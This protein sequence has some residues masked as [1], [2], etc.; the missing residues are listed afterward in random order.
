V[1]DRLESTNLTDRIHTWRLHGNAG[2]DR[3][4]SFT[5]TSQ[6]PT[7]ER[8][9]AGVEVSVASTEGKP[10]YS[11]PAYNALRT[12]HVHEFDLERSV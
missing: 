11:E 6:G 10:A 1:A 4:G 2:Y 9:K 3:G 7:F 12:P 8:N 5:F